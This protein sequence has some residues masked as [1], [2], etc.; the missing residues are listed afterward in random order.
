MAAPRSL[1]LSNIA[2]GTVFTDCKPHH[3]PQEFLSFL[4]R[5]DA[6]VSPELNVHLIVDNYATHRHAKVLVWLATGHVSRSTT[7]RHIP[8]GSIR[9]HASLL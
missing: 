5:I 2:T 3:H 6:A 7:R 1:F 9:W 8:P 4:K